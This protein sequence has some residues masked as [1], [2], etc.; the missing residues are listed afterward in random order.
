MEI[1]TPNFRSSI[2]DDSMFYQSIG[3]LSERDDHVMFEFEHH[4]KKYIRSAQ[5]VIMETRIGRFYQ[6]WDKYTYEIIELAQD[7]L[8]KSLENKFD[9]SI[10]TMILSAERIMTRMKCE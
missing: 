3:S 5:M 6:N 7:A 9:K 2:E 4:G 1:N 8:I 10:L